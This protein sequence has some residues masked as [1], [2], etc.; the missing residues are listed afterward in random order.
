MMRKPTGSR[1]T[2][3][4]IPLL[5]AQG[6]CAARGVP[7]R[8]FGPPATVSDADRKVCED[9]ARTQAAAVKGRSVGD[10]VAEG[11][12]GGFIV[13]AYPFLVTGIFT[14]PLGAIWGGIDRAVDN[15]RDRQHAYEREVERCLREGSSPAQLD[16]GEVPPRAEGDP[17]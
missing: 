4:V 11:F 1:V 6:A 3:I 13:G 7:A 9:S 14:A 2:W 5:L 15:M 8:S 10:G 12:F 17:S 16:A